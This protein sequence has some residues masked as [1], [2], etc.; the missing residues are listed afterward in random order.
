MLIPGM[1]IVQHYF[2]ERRTLAV[3][4]ATMGKSLGSVAFGPI[5]RVLIDAYGWRGG[6]L[7][8]AG[9]VL[10][11]AVFASLMRPLVGAPKHKLTTRPAS[12]AGKIYNPQGQA[13]KS[14]DAQGRSKKSPS[15]SKATVLCVSI[16]KLFDVSLMKEGRFLL[17][18]CGRSLSMAGGQVM[19]TYAVARAVSMDIGKLD[20]SFLLTA[21]GGASAVGRFLIGAIADTKCAPPLVLYYSAIF[22]GGILA[23]LSTLAREHLYQH[24]ILYVLFGLTMGKYVS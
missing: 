14:E 10:Q 24:I 8:L 22:V 5:L 4:I 19:M 23:C 21:M 2:K 3:G 7:L 12:T 6:T 15:K 20:A 11:G 1:V 9:I 13:P 18:L 17:F 16:V